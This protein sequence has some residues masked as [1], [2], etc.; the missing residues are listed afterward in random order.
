MPQQHALIIDDNTMNV[1]VLAF[2]LSD[3]GISNT[4]V[5]NPKHLDNILE[6]EE[7]IDIVFLDLEMPGLNGYEVLEKL[8]SDERFQGVPVVAYTV[9]ANEMNRAHQLGFHSFLGKPIDAD[10]FPGQLERILR[11]ES[12]WERT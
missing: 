1:N 6:T 8:K 12:V 4:P 5:G 3:Q 7:K 9:H 11:G 2:L 10:R